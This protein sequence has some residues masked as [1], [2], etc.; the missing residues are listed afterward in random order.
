MALEAADALDERL[1]LCH[2]LRCVVGVGRGGLVRACV[3][4]VRAVRLYDYD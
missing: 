2:L 1:E 3:G 4:G